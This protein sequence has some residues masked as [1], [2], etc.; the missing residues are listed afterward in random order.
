VGGH[1]LS[2]DNVSEMSKKERKKSLL[3]RDASRVPIHLV[4]VTEDGVCVVAYCL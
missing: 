1:V 3:A 4:L 2:V